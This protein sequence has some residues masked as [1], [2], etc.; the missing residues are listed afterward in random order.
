MRKRTYAKL[1]KK[2]RERAAC[3]VWLAP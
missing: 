1:A 3:L 2:I